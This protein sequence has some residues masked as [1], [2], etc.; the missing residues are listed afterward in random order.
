MF[1]ILVVNIGSTSFKFQ[2]IDMD[3]ETALAKGA[4]ERVGEDQSPMKYELRS[5]NPA[6]L[7]MD[8][9]SGFNPC[10]KKMIE[11]LIDKTD[12]VIR[13]IG[14]IDAVGFKTVHA[15]DIRAPSLINDAIIM[16]MEDYAPVVPAHNPPYIE[17]IRQFRQMLPDIPLVAVFESF[18]HQDMPEHASLYSVPHEWREKYQVQKYGF[19][20]ASHRFVMERAA[21]ILQRPL[22]RFKL[23]SCH[24][25]G[26][27]S[28]SAIKN[29]RSIDNSMGFSAQA[30][31]PMSKRCGD[32]DPFVIPLVMSKAHLSFSEVMEILVQKSGLLGISGISGD[33]R[34]LEELASQGDHRAETALDVFI[35]S[36]KKYIGAYAA[37]MGGMDA[38]VFAGGIG[39]NAPRIRERICRDMEFLGLVLDEARNE[40]CGREALISPD[41]ARIPILVIP[42]NEEIIVAKE[43]LK[44]IKN[45]KA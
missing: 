39:E 34:R 6:F 38:L 45:K 22:E 42:T 24:L 2:L 11:I 19:H 25:G 15:G 36:V 20:G 9:R 26:S 21:H 10:I 35:Y 28:V 43:T 14:E 37:A 7:T 29:G 12:G 31:I 44:V 23:V 8:T 1:R 17:A 13:D 27:S 4:V 41:A 18:F 30:G 3:A 40:C 33:V 32:L 5:G 16:A